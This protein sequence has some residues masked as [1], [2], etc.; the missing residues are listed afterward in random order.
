M[1]EPIVT[2]SLDDWLTKHSVD[3]ESNAAVDSILCNSIHSAAASDSIKMNSSET[4]SPLLAA[5]TTGV[6][7]ALPC[8]RKSADTG[9]VNVGG[10]QAKKSRVDSAYSESCS[11]STSV[12]ATYK[13]KPLDK[14]SFKEYLDLLSTDK[15]M[16]EDV[17]SKYMDI[18]EQTKTVPVESDVITNQLYSLMNTL[19]TQ[20]KIRQQ[21]P[22]MSLPFVTSRLRLIFKQNVSKEYGTAAREFLDNKLTNPYSD[23]RILS[24]F[25]NLGCVTCGDNIANAMCGTCMQISKCQYCFD[26]S[27]CSHC[28]NLTKPILIG[29]KRQCNDNKKFEYI[30]PMKYNNSA[31]HSLFNNVLGPT[32]TWMKFYSSEKCK[33]IHNKELITV[34]G[35]TFNKGLLPDNKAHFYRQQVEDRRNYCKQKGWLDEL[36]LI[37]LAENIAQIDNI[38]LNLPKLF[39]PWTVHTIVCPY[40]KVRFVNSVKK[41]KDGYFA[42]RCLSCATSYDTLIKSI[43]EDGSVLTPK[44]RGGSFFKKVKLT[45]RKRQP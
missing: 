11:P 43:Q 34:L 40:C 14:R 24:E 9:C 30:C 17:R 5:L 28:T 36:R 1:P 16:F 38:N 25:D 15:V 23:F 20:Y 13:Q 39:P 41:V 26:V 27:N 31:I 44:F 10:S 21:I 4:T 12:D 7:P 32:D 22:P 33:F 45:S 18:V 8:K 29:F 6:H 2:R 35:N 19:D 3:N 42:E 37:S